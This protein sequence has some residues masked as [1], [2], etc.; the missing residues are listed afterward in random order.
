MGFTYFPAVPQP[1]DFPSASQGQFLSNFQYLNAFGN[2]DHELTQNTSNA[3]D[4]THKQV[5]LTNQTPTPGFTGGSSVLYAN[6]AVGQS[7]LFFNNAAGDIQLTSLKA[8]VPTSATSGVSFLP[9]GIL[10]QWGQSTGA[11]NGTNSITFP[12]AFSATPFSITC[13]QQFVNPGNLRE[14]VQVDLGNTNATLWTPRLINDGGGNVSGT[15]L[16]LWMAIGPV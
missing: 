1:G 2:R 10:I 13:N 5:T 8:S 3:N 7:Q 12:V 15:R 4:G 14:F 6:S 16:L 11:W 9:G